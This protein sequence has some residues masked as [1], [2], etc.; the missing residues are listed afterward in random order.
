MAFRIW[1]LKHVG[2]MEVVAVNT[3]GSMNV[4]GWCHLVNQDTTYRRFEIEIESEEKI[5]DPLIGYLVVPSMSL[6]IPVLA[7]KDPEK[8]PWSKYG[9]E[10]VMECT[11]KFTD[12]PGALKHAKAGA[13]RMIFFPTT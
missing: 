11:G 1:L 2:E 9:V 10:V 13:K 7:Q 12:E 8:L 6:K 3:S 4:A 5:E